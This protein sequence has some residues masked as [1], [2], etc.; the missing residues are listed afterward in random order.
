MPPHVGCTWLGTCARTCKRV[1]STSNF[2]FSVN[3]RDQLTCWWTRVHRPLGE[4]ELKGLLPF[5]LPSRI[6][7]REIG[8]KGIIPLPFAGVSFSWE[9]EKI[10]FDSTIAVAS[11]SSSPNPRWEWLILT[12]VREVLGDGFGRTHQFVWTELGINPN[13]RIYESKITSCFLWKWHVSRGNSVKI[14]LKFLKIL[15]RVFFKR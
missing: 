15:T 7:E 13:S 4:R 9:R 1:W 14:S 10:L 8:R 11:F 3:W 6:K 5:P 12:I 2:G